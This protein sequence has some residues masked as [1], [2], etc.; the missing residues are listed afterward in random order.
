MTERELT[1]RSLLTGAAGL[2][3]GG[4]LRPAGALAALGRSA[5]ARLAPGRPP[6]SSPS[7]SGPAPG[8]SLA[9]P[10]VVFERPLGTLPGGML[11]RAVRLGRNADLLGLRWSGAPNADVQLRFANGRGGWSRWAFAGTHGHGPDLPR[12]A[13]GEGG[14]RPGEGGRGL[15]ALQVG[16]PLWS[17]GGDTVQVRSDRPLH[18][19][20]L[21]A[22][23]VSDGAGARA[24][25]QFGWGQGDAR[26]G[27]AGQGRT[28]RGGVRQGGARQS[29]V[30][31]GGAGQGGARAL[32]AGLALASPVLAAGAGQPPILA[33]RSWA[34]GHA[35]PRVAPEYG[36]VRMA[37]VHHTENPNGYTPGEVPAML[38]AIY[39]FHRYGNGWNDI[40]YNFVIDLY[41]R[42]FEARAGG[43]DEPV[44]GAHAG[45]YNY[46]ST[47]VAILGEFMS[48]P[49]SSA[50]RSALERLLAWKLSLHGAPSQGRVTVRVD[51]AGAVYSR[52]PAGAHVSL[53]RIAGHRDG[54]STDCPGDALYGQLPAIR[55][56]VR[57]LAPRPTR[58]TLMLQAVPIQTT[59]VQSQPPPPAPEGGASAPGTQP[60]TQA[61]AGGGSAPPPASP[62]LHGVL[63]LL[64]GAPIAA[65][66]ILLQARS[67]SHRGE[68]VS[69]RTLAQ[70]M[71]DATGAWSLPAS[72]PTM[73]AGGQVWLRALYLG[74]SAFGAAVSDP[75]RVTLSP[76]AAPA[77]TPPAPAPPGP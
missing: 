64:D 42:I 63:Q 47:G 23:D 74:S 58:A 70:A 10:P 4:L 11:A 60:P 2:A 36:T 16:E 33:R 66:Q 20:R 21:I 57:Q 67:V 26:Q 45:G 39:A 68:V 32:A 28:G 14:G 48:T 35:P 38:R 51:P 53:P 15:G 69:E 7:T 75:L 31:Q 3:A 34:L 65:G 71:T 9:A 50:A 77:P 1:R 72:F 8:G 13:D 12:A 17:G 43:I 62:T 44:I 40:G 37:F 18:E 59:P 5:P 27:R 29:G 54:D 19:V 30:R 6:V 41:G 76:V 49:I 22:I 61:P 55:A 24:L 52:F 46:V 56:R 73:P 25:A